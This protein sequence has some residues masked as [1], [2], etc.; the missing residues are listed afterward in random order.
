MSP[1]LPERRQHQGNSTQAGLQVFAKLLLPHQF[2]QVFAAAGQ[3]AHVGRRGAVC[4]RPAVLL[5]QQAHQPGLVVGVQAA[6]F[7]KQDA[8][9]SGQV[10]PA[11][12][13]RGRIG[14]TALLG[15]EQV[16]LRLAAAG[17]EVYGGQRPVAA[18][19][20]QWINWARSCSA[21]PRLAHDQDRQI[22]VG[23]AADGGSQGFNGRRL[24]DQKVGPWRSSWS[25]FGG[26]KIILRRRDVIRQTTCY[27]SAICLTTEVRL[28]LDR[29]LAGCYTLGL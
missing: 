26:G 8:A 29:P 22:G 16:I 5:V 23:Q 18:P 10:E 27:I 12:R 1:A 7:P 3:D 25:R 21:C 11:R 13:S 28:D 6:D 20:K 14:R 2:A 9:A 4:S 19:L 15:G 24:A 17:G